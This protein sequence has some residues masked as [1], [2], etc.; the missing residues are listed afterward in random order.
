MTPFL[1]SLE[2]AELPYGKKSPWNFLLR[3]LPLYKDKNIIIAGIPNC[4]KTTFFNG[5][6]GSKRRVGNWPGVTVDRTEGTLALKHGDVHLVD[7][8]GTY[9][10]NPDT[11]DQIIAARAISSQEHDLV[12]NV[13]DASNLSRNLFLTYDILKLTHN[14]IVVLNMVDV[15]EQEGISI[16]AKKL[17]KEL[18][19]PVCP[20]VAVDKKSVN[21]LKHLIDDLLVDGFE[22]TKKERDHLHDSSL[23]YEHIDEVCKEVTTH[24]KKEMSFTDKVDRIVLNKFFALP[25]FLGA[26]FLTF[27]FAIRVGG[28]FIDFFDII[29]GLI[30]V[31][32]LGTVLQSIGSPDWL[33]SFLADGIGT[34]IQ[35]V[36]TFIPVMFFMFLALAIL[37]DL[38][39]MSRIAVI[40]DKVMRKIGLPG[41]AFIPLVVGFGCTVPAIMSARTLPTKRD[42]F[43][44]IFMAPFMSCGA[45]LPVYALFAAALFRTNSALIVF[46]IYLTG[47]VMAILTGLLLKNTLFR[48]KESPFLL[49]LPIYHRPRIKAIIK[50][51]TTRTGSFIKRAGTVITLA[52]TILGFFNS[53]GYSSDEGITF[54]NQDSDNSVLTYMGKTISPI[55]VPM[56][57]SE[58]NWPASVALFSG[59]FAK[60]SIIGTINSLYSGMD[61]ASSDESDE[62]YEFTPLETIAEAFGT[63][64]DEFI[65]LFTSADLLGVGLVTE[66]EDAIAE[67]GDADT[68]VFYH[69]RRNFTPFSAFSYLLFVL[70]YFPCFAVFGAAKKEM[71][72]KYTALFSAYLTS[73]A[74]AVATLFYQI[75]EGRNI[76]YGSIAIGVFGLIYIMF[77]VIGNMSTE[78]IT[79]S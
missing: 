56:G 52:V 51:S 10:L 42:R 43:M 35:T 58:D 15:A 69:I 77:R 71:G 21:N 17:S 32:G 20:L 31:D 78:K 48:G 6:T 29:G 8:P 46:I 61:A 68:A 73:L 75:A 40:A 79:Q 53:M 50:S 70:L 22:I 7:L 37:E 30:F 49:D 47:I 44:T 59:L 74:W 45:R 76:L 23:T 3:R 39:Y 13:V 67:E 1:L 4:G 14:V 34:G 66:G 38:G 55:F 24:H 28:V 2:E 65:D 36:G 41:N 63:V 18:G 5:V 27:W 54:G 19:V 72:W 16:D 33:T 9:N 62:R 11:E 60:E 57:I 25:I 64:K 12:I 26:M